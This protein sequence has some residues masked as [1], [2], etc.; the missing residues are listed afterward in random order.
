MG[1]VITY[2]T[3]TKKEFDAVQFMCEQRRI[4]SN[5]LSNMTKSEIVEYFKKKRIE[6]VHNWLLNPAD[7]YTWPLAEVQLSSKNRILVKK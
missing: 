5:K 4:L 6:N 1:Q 7:A 3:K 2:E